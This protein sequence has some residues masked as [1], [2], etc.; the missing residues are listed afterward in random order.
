MATRTGED[1][2]LTIPNVL[3]LGRLACIPVFLWLLFGRDNPVGAALLLGVLG[4][5]DWVDGTVARRFNQVSTLGKVLDPTADRI[6]LGVAV[7]A[8]VV[9]G[10]VPAV[11]GW[12]VIVREAAVS[13]G[14]LVLAAMGARRI[15]VSW[16]GKIGTLGLM[17]SFPLF[18]LAHEPSFG[19]RDAV[20]VV[21]WAAALVGLAC[22]YWAA[23]RYVG[24]A[25][26]ALAAGRA[27][28]AERDGG[29]RRQG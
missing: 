22:G 20:R 27:D 11:L 2:I 25:R 13:I 26:E 24:A 19:G 23:F 14:V 18:L 9:E 7:V 4:A 15:D 1:R 8:I 10:A 3:S 5:T 6:L 16:A 17:V 21:A 28:R 12:P 29:A